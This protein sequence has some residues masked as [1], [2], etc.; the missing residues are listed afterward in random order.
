MKPPVEKNVVYQVTG[1]FQEGKLTTEEVSYEWS[2]PG[3][4]IGFH[5]YSKSYRTALH[6]LINMSTFSKNVNILSP[7]V[8]KADNA[9]G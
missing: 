8:K 2:H 3:C 6:A 7:V 5:S 9:S 4:V 1:D